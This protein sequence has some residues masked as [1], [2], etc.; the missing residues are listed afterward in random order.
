MKVKIKKM[1]ASIQKMVA[2]PT[3]CIVCALFFI[4]AGCEDK[5]SESQENDDCIE[6][7]G[8][9]VRFTLKSQSDEIYLSTE[10]SD[11]Q[12]LIDIHNVIFYQTWPD[13]KTPELLLLYTLT[14][15]WCDKQNKEKAIKDFLATGKFEDDVYEY[16]YAHTN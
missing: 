1:Y 11:I 9:S 3:L 7:L 10:G 8:W 12:S 14:G 2:M 5:K 6:E 4:T 16:G 13:A 15:R